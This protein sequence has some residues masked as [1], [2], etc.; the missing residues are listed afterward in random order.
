MRG[1]RAG[2]MG[3][4]EK[5]GSFSLQGG[6]T[7]STV[8]IPGKDGSTLGREAEPRHLL[9]QTWTLL[10]EVLRKRYRLSQRHMVRWRNRESRAN[11]PNFLQERQS[12]KL[13]RR[14][15]KTARQATT[16]SSLERS[17]ETTVNLTRE[18]ISS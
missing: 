9:S 17:V 15:Q 1:G 3:W 6:R 7:W 10:V 18:T 8:P 11:P 16:K 12:Q 2:E 13:V 14:E 4:L 5:A